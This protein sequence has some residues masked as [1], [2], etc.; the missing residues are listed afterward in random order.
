M[1]NVTDIQI[2]EALYKAAGNV[3][4]AAR[5][6]DRN[7]VGLHK[8]IKKSKSL[9]EALEGFRQHH[10]DIAESLVHRKFRF[11]EKLS[12]PKTEE[13]IKAGE[14]EIPPD[15]DTTDLA[16]KYLKLQGKDRGYSERSEITGAN[17]APV[18][19]LFHQGLDAVYESLKANPDLLKKVE[20]ELID[21]D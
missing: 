14:V 7:Y 16:L 5:Q 9:T 20:K 15:K 19:V 8:R 12:R 13:E 6:L 1:G 11:A 10:V 17:G 4:E 21:E 2:E 18:G 3:S